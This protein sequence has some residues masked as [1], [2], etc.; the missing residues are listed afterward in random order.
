[1]MLVAMYLSAQRF[2]LKFFPSVFVQIGMIIFSFMMINAAIKCKK[3]GGINWRGTI[4][5]VEDLIAGQRVKF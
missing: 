4:Y 2:G 3:Q 1:V 5:P